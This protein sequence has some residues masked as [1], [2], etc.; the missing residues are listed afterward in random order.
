MTGESP[1]LSSRVKRKLP[2]SL[3]GRALSTWFNPG[4][5]TG[6]LF[7]LANCA[8]MFALTVAVAAVLNHFNLAHAPKGAE[9]PWT[10]EEVSRIAWFAVVRWPISPSTSASDCWCCAGCGGSFSRACC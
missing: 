8:A 4:P 3:L 7:A 6:Y 2:Q 5:G 1:E 10:L 9:R